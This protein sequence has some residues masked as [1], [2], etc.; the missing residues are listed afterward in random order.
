M[1]ESM[2]T[3]RTARHGTVVYCPLEMLSDGFVSPTADVYALAVIIGEMIAGRLV[4]DGLTMAQAVLAISTDD[5]RP[6][7]EAWIPG[8]LRT[9]LEQGWSSNRSERPTAQTFFCRLSAVL[10]TVE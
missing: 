10:D 8:E 6:E 2:R 1:P 3:V 5:L 7:L 9:L 4:Y